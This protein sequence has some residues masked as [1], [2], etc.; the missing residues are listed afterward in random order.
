MQKKWYRSRRNKMIGGVAGGL[1]EYFD[2]DPTI[3]RLLFV[4]GLFMGAGFLAYIIMWIV[5]PEEPYF[6]ETKTETNA[7]NQDPVKEGNETPNAEQKNEEQKVH[8][9]HRKNRTHFFGAILVILGVLLLVDNFV[10]FEA[11]WPLLLILLGVG[12][13]LNSRKS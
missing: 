5:V 3:V 6:N 4:V 11:F 10:R 13:L 8:K 12:V 7:D 9:E 1:A 2:I